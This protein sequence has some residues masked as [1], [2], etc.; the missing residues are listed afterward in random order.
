MSAV[1]YDLSLAARIVR[2]AVRDKT[3]RAYPL[4]Q[5][6]GHFLRFK[7]KRLT[8]DSYRDYEACLDKLARF[9]MDLDLGDFEPPMGTERVEELLDERWGERAPRTYNKNLSILREFFK[10]AVLRQK[11]HGDPTLPIERAKARGTYRT[12][13]TTDQRSALL[14]LKRETPSLEG[15]SPCH[16]ER[17]RAGGCAAGRSTSRHGR[18][19]WANLRA[20]L[21]HGAASHPSARPLGGSASP[22]RRQVGQPPREP[23]A[24]YQIG[25]CLSAFGGD[26]ALTGSHSGARA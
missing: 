8:K 13:F 16:I 11:L 25:S 19:P 26:Q 17:L 21:R 20:S 12:T 23:R 18:R 4:G 3:Y 9:Y 24:D 14:A 5:E 1:A 6:A 7:R 22:K 2:E 15:W 10:W